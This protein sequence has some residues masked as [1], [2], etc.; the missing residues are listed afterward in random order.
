MTW[1]FFCLFFMLFNVIN[2]F[3]KQHSCDTDHKESMLIKSSPYHKWSRQK[4]AVLTRRYSKT[5]EKKRKNRRLM[6][7]NYKKPK[8]K[9]FE[10]PIKFHIIYDPSKPEE[11][12]PEKWINDQIKILNNDFRLLNNDAWKIVNTGFNHIASMSIFT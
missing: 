12:V 4:L 10:I 3:D 5:Q 6:T 1:L 8:S 9:H 11:N 7:T 2:S